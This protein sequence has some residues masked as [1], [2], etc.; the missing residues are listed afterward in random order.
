MV[1][2]AW[3]AAS[4][5]VAIEA[6]AGTGK[7]T[8]ISA[9]VALT[10]MQ[11]QLVLTHTH[12][13]VGAIHRALQKQGV[14]PRMC[15][16]NTIAGWALR[17][18]SAYP[19]LS[20]LK[21]TQPQNEEWEEVY[22]CAI[23]VVGHKAVR[24]VIQESYAGL[25]V[26]EYQDCTASQHALVVALADILPCRVL[27]DPLQGIFEFVKTGV[28]TWEKDVAGCFDIHHGPTVPWRWQ[29]K[30]PRLGAWLGEVRLAL[31]RNEP[32]D[33]RFGPINWMP[34][35]DR[36]AQQIQIAAARTPRAKDG[37]TVVAMQKWAAGAHK[38]SSV[39]GG[40]FSSIE[41]IECPELVAH[42]QFIQESSGLARAVAVID[43]AKICMTHVGT[44]LDS[45]RTAMVAGRSPSSKKAEKELDALL[46]VAEST[47]MEPVVAALN[48]IRRVPGA[49]LY[50]RELYDEMRR[51]LSNCNEGDLPGSAW[52]TRNL[53]RRIGRKLATH[54]VG[55]TLLVK[56]LEFD[57][58]VILDAEAVGNTKEHLY[59]ALTRGS[60]SLTVVSRYP[61]LTYGQQPPLT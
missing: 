47:Q 24:E 2:A 30:N 60:R 59:V 32:I 55:T 12:A 14:S 9:A 51:S 33:L 54:S 5:R 29:E 18:A 44:H 57:H 23:T 49:S 31:L 6:P 37:E 43:F 34:I 25:Y 39:L 10:P 28:V 20:G 1:D 41:S 11:H 13:G 16:V 50:R 19:S 45:I 61:L 27:G 38:A 40:M 48:V 17:Y 4:S 26:D 15:H 52:K 46:R 35:K 56:G 7:T 8:L 58:A 22:R 53:T 42:A 21:I 3:L 36:P